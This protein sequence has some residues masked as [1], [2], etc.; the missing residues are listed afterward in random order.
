MEVLQRAARAAAVHRAGPDRPQRAV[1]DRIVAAIDQLGPEQDTALYRTTRA[2]QQTM[3]QNFEADKINAIVLLSDGANTEP[4]NPDP[5][6]QDLDLLLRDINAD[7]LENSIRI[8][9]IPYG[10][11]AQ[12]DVLAKISAA[13]KA[14]T[15]DARNPLDIDD[16]FVSV[17]RNF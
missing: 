15:Y 4:D 17:F 5:E 6:S 12:T 8:F 16:V 10:E 9:T 2:A 3:V 13:S 11:Q 14:A 7:R 1:H